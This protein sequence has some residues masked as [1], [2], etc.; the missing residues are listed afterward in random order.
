MFGVIREVD[1]LTNE[2]P[3]GSCSTSR[4]RWL[5]RRSDAD[6]RNMRFGELIS[7]VVSGCGPCKGRSESLDSRSCGYRLGLCIE[8][9]KLT[10]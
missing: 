5:A 4:N 9:D 6:M 3:D 10:K 2:R 1:S 7:V 8:V